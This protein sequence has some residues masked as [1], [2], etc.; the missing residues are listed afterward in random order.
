[1]K[2]RFYVHLAVLSLAALFSGSATAAPPVSTWMTPA[3]GDVVSAQTE[4]RV[5]T[6]V[7]ATSVEFFAGGVSLGVVSAPSN[8]SVDT[9]WRMYLEPTEFPNGPLQLSVSA[10]NADG[11]SS[12]RAAP[13]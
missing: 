10:T 1:M 11:T 12:G 9:D 8:P 3:P 13:G 2:S 7:P 4:L 5:I 6:D